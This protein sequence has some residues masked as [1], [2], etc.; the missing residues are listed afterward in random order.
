MCSALYQWLVEAEDALLRMIRGV[1]RFISEW[2][3]TWIYHFVVDGIWPV[4][5]RL[6]RVLTLACLWLSILFG[7][8]TIGLVFKLRWWWNCGSTAWMVSA[9][10]GSIWGLSRLAK[11]R[12]AAVS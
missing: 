12:K 5:I 3:P 9:I 10:I 11:K 6:S 4:V 7:P 2:L 8:L 1:F